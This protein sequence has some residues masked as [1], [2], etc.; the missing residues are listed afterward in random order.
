M[1]KLIFKCLF[2]LWS[3]L[4]LLQIAEIS[5]SYSVA[6][7]RDSGVEKWSSEDEMEPFRTV[8]VF[9]ADKLQVV[10]DKIKHEL[11]VSGT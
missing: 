3:I 9:P 2:I 6:H 8:I 1:F 4:F 5:F 10:I 7:E 11:A